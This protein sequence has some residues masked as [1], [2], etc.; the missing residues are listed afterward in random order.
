MSKLNYVLDKYLIE[1]QRLLNIKKYI[2]GTGIT[3]GSSACKFLPSYT[4]IPETVKPHHKD[5]Y[6]RAFEEEIFILHDLIHQLFPMD[7]TVD[8][9]QYGDRQ[10][11]GELVVFYIVEFFI[12]DILIKSPKVSKSY[13]EYIELR[14]Y[15]PI[16]K[17]LLNGRSRTELLTLIFSETKKDW[18]TEYHGKLGKIVEM[19]KMD[20][21]NS[22][23]NFNLLP[24]EFI[25]NSQINDLNSISKHFHL[26]ERIISGEEVPY[27]NPLLSGLPNE[28]I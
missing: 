27:K 25:A 20:H 28:W 18:L 7:L 15:Y 12:Q 21:N 26:F 19:F 9:D 6:I 24:K 4:E 13:C 11:M 17:E 5:P 22:R 8:I 23:H 2:L 16:L 14:G 10:V 1:D 3:M